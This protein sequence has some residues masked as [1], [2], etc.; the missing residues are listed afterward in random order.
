MHRHSWVEIDLARLKENTRRL[1]RW[2]GDNFFCPMV[3]ANAYGHG[4]V[5]VARALAEVGV[6][7]IGV[8][9]VEE[10]IGLREAGLTLPILVF[11]PFDEAGAAATV[12]HGLTPVVGR[13]E[14]L[15]PFRGRRAD[16][17]VKIN[18]GM[19]RLG[20]DAGE[21][22]ALRSALGD[23]RVTGVCTHLTHGEDAALSD[24]PTAR[25]LARFRELSEGL[26]G[27]RHAHK[28]ASLGA[29]GDRAATGGL[30]ARPG[31]ALHGL[32]YEGDLVGEGLRPTLS[33]KS[34]LA[35]V[36]HLKQGQTVGYGA[37]WTAPRDTTLGVVPIG[38][39]DGF[40]RRYGG[41]AE[42][43][44]GGRRVPVVGSVCMDYHYVDLGDALAMSGE[45]VVIIGQQGTAEVSAADLARW[46]DTISYEVVTAIS[47][48]V[49]RR[50]V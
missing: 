11:A 9:L 22:P 32:P 42:V 18:T 43:L 36:H 31:I 6:D 27:V 50:S 20:F 45:P 3:K 13:P 46:A 35:A 49:P 40:S 8:A 23:L 1:K 16:I 38:Y 25:Q 30:G 15:V 10:G 24:G 26:P 39:G 37:R 19:Q 17:H 48:R 7:A 5:A 29:L 21:L 4:D 2:T 28:S 47:S 12:A 33:W 34:R 14:H 41:R 44:V